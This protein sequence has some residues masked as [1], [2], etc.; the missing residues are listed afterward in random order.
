VQAVLSILLLLAAASFKELLELAIYAEWLFYMIA[1]STIF[2]FRR[3]DPN[4]NRPYKV[5]G[6]PVVPALFIASSAVLLYFTFIESLRNSLLGTL[7]IL[8]GIPIFLYF[9][10]KRVEPI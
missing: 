2:V 5:W 3:R 8:G 4:A 1:G 7:V 10:A 9:K 6:Y